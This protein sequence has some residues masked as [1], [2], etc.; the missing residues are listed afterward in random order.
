MARGYRSERAEKPGHDCGEVCVVRTTDS[1]VLCRMEDNDEVWFPFSQ[2]H[3]DSEINDS[4]CEEE[5][6][7]QLVVTQWIAKKKDLLEE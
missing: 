1:A 3:S 6:E 5:L 4:N 2:I 7:A